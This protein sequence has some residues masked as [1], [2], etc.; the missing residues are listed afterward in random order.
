MT[1]PIDIDSGFENSDWIKRADPKAQAADIAASDEALRI[2]NNAAPPDVIK[3]MY[4]AEKAR[5]NWGHAGRPGQRGGSAPRG[6]ITREDL[7]QG[8]TT[9]SGISG[10]DFST[11][12]ARLL[13][14]TWSPSQKTLATVGSQMGVQNLTK[15]QLVGNMLRKWTS[16]SGG[17]LA[18]EVIR[19]AMHSAGIS[20][21]SLKRNA[22][23]DANPTVKND[24]ASLG[25]LMYQRTQDWFS[26]RGISTV[27]A[28]RLGSS[29]SSSPFSSWSIGHAGFITQVPGLASRTASIPINRILS[30]PSTG[31]GNL[32]E[33]EIVVMGGMP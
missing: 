13:A 10:R 30:I 1:R 26:S 18:V 3:K 16:S 32:A 14:K 17:P 8:V 29:T 25:S 23:M 4:E 24:L 15:E 27:T 7:M 28:T 20:D 9:N 19:G 33:T 12:V 22:W 2:H 6:G 5:G 11:A 31:F 21:G